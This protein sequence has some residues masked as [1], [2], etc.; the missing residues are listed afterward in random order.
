MDHFD[1]KYYILKSKSCFLLLQKYSEIRQKNVFVSIRKSS[2]SSKKSKK[3]IAIRSL[4]LNRF[5]P[6]HMNSKVALLT[7]ISTNLLILLR[8][9]NV[10]KR[11]NMRLLLSI[12]ELVKSF[13]VRNLIS[14]MIIKSYG[15]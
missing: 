6:K 14:V 12:V 4:L 10:S 8:L 13:M 3:N 11:P 2:N 1:P 9:R 15:I 7:L 5:K